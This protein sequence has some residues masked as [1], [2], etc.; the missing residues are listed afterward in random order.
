[1]SFFGF[2]V[3]RG[4]LETRESFVL[5]RTRVNTTNPRLEKSRARSKRLQASVKPAARTAD[6]VT[7]NAPP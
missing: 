5:S 3:W 7:P 1:M 6:T 2:E 4:D